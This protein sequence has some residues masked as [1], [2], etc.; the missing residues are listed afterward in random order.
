MIYFSGKFGLKEKEI[1]SRSVSRTDALRSGSERACPKRKPGPRKASLKISR[2]LPGPTVGALES[3]CKKPLCGRRLLARGTKYND[4]VEL[5]REFF[6]N[7]IKEIPPRDEGF[8]A[9]GVTS[10]RMLA[11]LPYLWFQEIPF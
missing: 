1:S 7:Q 9:G 10:E 4:K 8:G 6:V 5:P 11:V 3:Q 2:V